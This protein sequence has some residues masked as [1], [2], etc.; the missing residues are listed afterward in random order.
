MIDYGYTSVIFGVIFSSG[1]F[2]VI[3]RR[4]WGMGSHVRV[5]EG[6]IYP[7]I[8]ASILV[9]M[10]FCVLGSDFDLPDPLIDLLNV[11]FVLVVIFRKI[12]RV[13]EIVHMIFV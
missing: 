12:V 2:F 9:S 6:N 7:M 13:L 10:I 1:T 5:S 8:V 11:T 4:S 3:S